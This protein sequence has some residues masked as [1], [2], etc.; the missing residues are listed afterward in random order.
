M[1]LLPLGECKLSLGCYNIFSVTQLV[2]VCI[3]TEFAAFLN[4]NEEIKEPFS[5]TSEESLK[6]KSSVVPRFW[7]SPSLPT[8]E[9]TAGGSH[10]TATV[11]TNERLM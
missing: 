1:P 6:A 4:V 2:L 9:H 7:I 3:L 8:K 10:F 11:S 5:S